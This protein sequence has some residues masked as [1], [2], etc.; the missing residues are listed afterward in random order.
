M[1]EV[2]RSAYDIAGNSFT[3]VAGFFRSN[4]GNPQQHGKKISLPMQ[5]LMP[6]FSITNSI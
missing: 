5:V 4:I 1:Y 3:P 2:G 6:L